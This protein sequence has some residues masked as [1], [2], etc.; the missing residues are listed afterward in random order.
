MHILYAL[1]II[2]FVRR[3]ILAISVIF[4]SSLFMVKAGPRDIYI[5]NFG[6]LMDVWKRSDIGSASTPL[7]IFY[8][9]FKG[10]HGSLYRPLSV[11]IYSMLFLEGMNDSEKTEVTFVFLTFLCGISVFLFLF[12]ITRNYPVS[13]I[14]ALVFMFL[15]PFQ[16]ISWKSFD[17]NLIGIPLVFGSGILFLLSERS[18]YLIVPFII[19]SFMAI[20]S[21]EAGRFFIAIMVLSLLL[22]FR[23]EF[24]IGVL[25][26][27][28]VLVFDF[29][30]IFVVAPER[31]AVFKSGA[32]YGTR[33]KDLLYYSTFFL[34]NFI[35]SL[36]VITFLSA[37]AYL[38]PL[39]SN[40]LRVLFV[41][42]FI[43]IF[44]V[45][46]Y[47]NFEEGFT[48]V[49]QNPY[50]FVV[51]FIIFLSLLFYRLISGE[52]Y[53]RVFSSYILLAIFGII[54]SFFIY[55][56]VRKDISSRTLLY[57]YPFLLFPL[58]KA[59]YF[60]RRRWFAVFIFLSLL[61]HLSTSFVNRRGEENAIRR[62][63]LT[64]VKRII[65]MDKRER[66]RWN[67]FQVYIDYVLRDVYFPPENYRRFKNYII[68]S[69]LFNVDEFLREV[70]GSMEPAREN[71]VL[72]ERFRTSD[73]PFVLPLDDRIGLLADELRFIGDTSKVAELRMF[74]PD[75]T[76]LERYLKANGKLI[77]RIV[78]KYNLY[79]IFV[80]EVFQ[81]LIL[82]VPLKIEYAFEISLY[83]L[84]VRDYN[85]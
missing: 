50:F 57:I 63:M 84:Q 73:Y 26:S 82:G 62:G 37:I 3:H 53:E 23:K 29:L 13:L 59:I 65:K 81:R 67:L 12:V 79:P 40:R 45:F 30:I 83:H 24:K 85:E 21:G 77:W 10:Y 19:T 31:S 20:L 27:T 36:G 74:N 48:F 22:L 71:Y 6:S 1:G 14:T 80:P 44:P 41:L 68:V 33:I 7:E 55:S 32:I 70:E 5:Q 17:T 69:G 35:Y 54:L 9:S 38:L 56:H 8:K 15:P 52:T 66:G 42:P 64:G 25:L 47:R 58:F 28:V 75:D 18:P 49:F 16:F 46:P 43:F 60:E 2:P 34:S 78:N 39:T 51:L 11:W 76:P 61:F 72:I 4:F